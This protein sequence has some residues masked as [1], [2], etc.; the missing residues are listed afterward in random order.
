MTIKSKLKQTKKKKEKNLHKKLS[1]IPLFFDKP[2]EKISNPG[3]KFVKSLT[4]YAMKKIK[5]T[6]TNGSS[7]KSR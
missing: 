2:N 1:R 5:P 6:E 4:I 3:R 7:K